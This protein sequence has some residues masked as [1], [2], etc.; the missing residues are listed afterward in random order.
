MM[1]DVVV[2]IGGPRAGVGDVGAYLVFRRDHTPASGTASR[3]A[4]LFWC[5]ESAYP[6]KG[7]AGGDGVDEST[8]ALARPADVVAI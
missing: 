3:R 1:E 2:L 7:V 4:G 6:R 5:G 8:I